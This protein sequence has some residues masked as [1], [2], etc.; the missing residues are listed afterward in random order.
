MLDAMK[1]QGYIR[2]EVDIKLTRLIGLGAINWVAIGYKR[3]GRYNLD[4]VGEAIRHMLANGVLAPK[5]QGEA[6]TL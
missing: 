5:Y 6:V 3:G 1:V 4:Q 2:P